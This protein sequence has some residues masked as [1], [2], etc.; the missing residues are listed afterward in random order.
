MNIAYHVAAPP[1]A[2]PGTDALWQETGLLAG[3][4]GGEEISVYPFARPFPLTPPALFGWAVRE[5]L[6]ALDRTGGLH[7]LFS[8][9]PH[10]YPYLHTLRGPL[11]YT[12][13]AGGMPRRLPAWLLARATWVVSNARDKTALAHLGASRI[14]EILPGIPL[15]HFA[16]VPAPPAGPFTLLMASAPWT[17]AQFVHKG[18]DLLL[19][20]LPR[21]PEL[22]L[23]LLWR[24]S[25]SDVLQE[26]LHRFR[27]E[28][29]VEVIHQAVD[30]AALLHRI[31]AV[32]LLSDRAKWVKAWPHSL[33]EGLAAGRPVLTSSA[34][35]MSDFVTRHSLGQVLDGWSVD[36]LQSALA[37]LRQEPPL[38][39]EARALVQATFEPENMIK[40]YGQLYAAM[41]PV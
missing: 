37:R 22:R 11:L 38:R 35:A 30:V 20:T 29:Q 41:A 39:E 17:K 31:H 8:A 16:R 4:W 9:S 34:I 10:A 26:R 15:A 27:V 6:R 40:A 1:P 24:G 28:R 36:A 19:Q 13:V 32:V 18:V 12:V 7:H 2:L 21:F 14:H 23:V 3:R 25:H 5:R 33:V